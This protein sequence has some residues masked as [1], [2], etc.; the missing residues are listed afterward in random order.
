MRWYRATA[1]LNLPE[2]QDTAMGVRIDDAGV[3][4]ERYRA[5]VYVNGWLVGN[6]I[7]HVG[8]QREFVIP[9]GLLNPSGGNEISLAVTAEEPGVGPDRVSLVAQHTTLGG[10]RAEQVP[11]PGYG[12]VRR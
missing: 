6:Y 1:Q 4:R 9:G 10:P 12:Q 3:G 11:S 2:G 8:P 7:N 5:L